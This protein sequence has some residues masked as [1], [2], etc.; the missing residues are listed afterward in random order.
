MVLTI[1]NKMGKRG[2]AQKLLGGI[3]EA[4]KCLLPLFS[5]SVAHILDG[6]HDVLQKS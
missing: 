1:L 3:N 2:V 4:N 6:F 5:G